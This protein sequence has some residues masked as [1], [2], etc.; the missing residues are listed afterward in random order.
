MKEYFDL[1]RRALSENREKGSTYFEAHHIVPKSFGKKSN[2]VLLLPEE[3]YRCH[4]LLAEYFKN[5]SLYGKK[6]LWAFHR[7]SYDKVRK[8]TELE[9]AESRRILMHLWKAKKTEKHRK[10]MST[11]RKV[12]Y[13]PISELEGYLEQGWINTNR[14]KGT[15]RD[16]SKKTKEDLKRRAVERQTGKKGL[17]ARAAKGPYTVLYENGNKITAGSYPELASATGVSYSTLQ[18]RVQHSSGVMYKG[19][20][21]YKGT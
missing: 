2:T 8:L 18:Y 3:H 14:G 9:Y 11:V 19:F 21:V 20:A 12:K 16:L 5:H 4:K 15:K 10:N 7:L 13:I 6:M 1:I 17:E